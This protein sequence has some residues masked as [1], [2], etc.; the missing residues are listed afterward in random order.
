MSSS[1]APVP[2][3]SNVHVSSNP[4]EKS[5]SHVRARDA[6]QTFNWRELTRD[7]KDMLTKTRVYT[8]ERQYKLIDSSCNATI[9]TDLVKDPNSATTTLIEYFEANHNGDGMLRFCEFLR[10]E[11]EEA[12]GSAVLE[13]LADRIERAVKS[14]G[15]SGIMLSCTYLRTY[16]IAQ[17]LYFVKLK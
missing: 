10:D 16:C 1:V 9:K 5:Y 4:E 14:L 11:A 8:L 12:G 6:L 2:G 13:G 15:A 17:K 3:P 7:V